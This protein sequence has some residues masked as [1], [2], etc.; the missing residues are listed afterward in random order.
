MITDIDQSNNHKKRRRPNRFKRSKKP[1]KPIHYDAFN[2]PDHFLGTP[3]LPPDS[4][5]PQDINPSDKSDSRELYNSGFN[6]TSKRTRC[7]YVPSALYSNLYS[8]YFTVDLGMDVDPVLI[9]IWNRMSLIK[10]RWILDSSWMTSCL[11]LIGWGLIDLKTY[12]SY[13]YKE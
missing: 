10:K 9:L 13:M 11:L 4:Y 5:I 6:Q 8:E 2:Y 1:H 3:L 7:K 12:H